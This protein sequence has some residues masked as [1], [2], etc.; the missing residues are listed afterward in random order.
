MTGSHF[1]GPGE[2]LPAI[3]LPD[4]DG[5]RHSLTE[6]LDKKLLVFMWASW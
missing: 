1:I 6:Y 4:L 5:D 3:S 2:A